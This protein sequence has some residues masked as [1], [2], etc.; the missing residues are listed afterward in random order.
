MLKSEYFVVIIIST[1]M[2]RA[3]VY[4][5]CVCTC[6]RECVRAWK[7]KIKNKRQDTNM[8]L[9]QLFLSESTLRTISIN[10]NANVRAKVKMT[11]Y[12]RFVVVIGM[13]KKQTLDTSLF[14]FYNS[15][16]IFRVQR[17]K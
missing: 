10:N 9:V 15:P 11:Y 6:V 13:M 12:Q 1:F 4:V 8:G 16:T 7:G 17:P 5:V 2:H 3:C 14:I